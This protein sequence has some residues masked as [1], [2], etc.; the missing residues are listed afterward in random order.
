MKLISVDGLRPGMKLARDIMLGKSILISRT[1]PITDSVIELLHGSG[2]QGRIVVE[3][4]GP[5]PAIRFRDGAHRIPI[6]EK[7]HGIVELTGDVIVETFVEEGARL[8]C[9]G[10]LTIR[11]DI[12][13]FAHI[14]C[15][16]K[17]IV[18]GSVTGATAVAGVSLEVGSAGNRYGIPTLLGTIDIQQSF[19][20][21]R[22]HQGH[23]ELQTINEKI[24]AIS[25]VLAS[26]SQ[27]T[28][29]GDKLTAD[30]VKQVKKLITVYSHL[31]QLRQ[32]LIDQANTAF[33]IATNTIT[34]LESV[35]PEVCLRINETFFTTENKYPSLS[36]TLRDGKIV[37]SRNQ[38]KEKQQAYTVPS[39][40]K[41]AAE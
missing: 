23:Q 11:E 7:A 3:E 36:L 12:L 22:Q 14:L 24:T 17:M 15:T 28:R 4:N 37:C 1:M 10:D 2:F 29:Q 13:P 39:S 16:G 34:V 19:A 41:T 38:L 5:P 20:Q 8:W 31:Q 27:R 30:E 18:Q 26:Y 32:R 35:F 9:A 40:E 33:P 25:P 6:L 21:L